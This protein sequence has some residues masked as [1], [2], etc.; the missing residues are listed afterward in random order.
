[1]QDVCSEYLLRALHL[2]GPTVIVSIGRYCE[3]RVKLLVRQNLLDATQ[4][5]LLCIPHPS[6]RSLNNTSWAEKARQWLVDNGVI[7]YLMP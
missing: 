6:P 3:D 7:P 2:F 4:V 5:R 1:M